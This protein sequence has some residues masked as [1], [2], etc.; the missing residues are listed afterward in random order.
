MSIF[1]EYITLLYNIHFTCY[2][3]VNTCMREKYLYNRRVKKPTTIRAKAMGRL[4]MC[5]LHHLLWGRSL[6]ICLRLYIRLV[7]GPFHTEKIWTNLS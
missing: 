7:L 5:R 3:L 6:L 2:M 4:L 1:F